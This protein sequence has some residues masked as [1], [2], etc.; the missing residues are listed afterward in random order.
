VRGA[1][2]AKARL[3]RSSLAGGRAA[4]SGACMANAGGFRAAH[5]GGRLGGQ[6]PERASAGSCRDD[7]RASLVRCQTLTAEWLRHLAPCADGPTGPGA[8]IASICA[9][10]ST[11]PP[12]GLRC[13]GVAVRPPTTHLARSTATP[14]QAV[15]TAPRYI[16]RGISPAGGGTAGRS[17]GRRAKVRRPHVPKVTFAMQL[18]T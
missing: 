10:K 6:T 18:C 9:N 1:G 3:S 8:G 16:H 15:P 5:A 2:G 7:D 4:H 14:R 17:P 12:G 11:G 13:G